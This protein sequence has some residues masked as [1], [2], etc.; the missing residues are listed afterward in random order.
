MPILKA[1]NSSIKKAAEIIKNGG[2][3]A[4]PTETVYGL[5]AD[6]FNPKAIAKIFQAK[7]RPSDNPLIVHLRTSQDLKLVARNIPQ[8]A[9]QLIEKFWPG[10]LT[11]ILKNKKIIPNIVSG[12]LNTVAVRMPD[13]KIALELIKKVGSPLAAPSANIS[14]RPSGTDAKT[15]FEDFGNT[16]DL[17]LN[18]GKTK[19]GV[20]STILDLTITPPAILR[21]GGVTIEEIRKNIPNVLIA[22]SSLPTKGG[23]PK[24]PGMKYRH[25]APKAPLVL[26]NNISEYLKTCSEKRVGILATQENIK[27]FTNIK[28]NIISMGS[29]KNLKQCAQNLFACLRKFDKLDVKLI[30]CEAFPKSGLGAAIMERLEKAEKK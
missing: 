27:H 11:L 26:T 19:I 1:N 16:I 21:Q 13:N 29:R 3:V 14:G 10:P 8:I 9:H 4:F 23:T 25:Y 5:G 30:I 20:E 2:I 24:A 17:I 12:G 7:G 22:D 28:K 18:D 6:A 15:V